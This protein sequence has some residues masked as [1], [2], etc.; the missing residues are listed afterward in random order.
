MLTKHIFLVGFMGVGKTT[1]GRKLAQ[2]LNSDFIDLDELFVQQEGTS[3]TN[4]FKIHGEEHF[5]LKEREIIQQLTNY[6]PAVIATGGGAPCFFDNMEW[7]NTHGITVYLQIPAAAL[8][9]RLA[10]SKRHKRPLIQ[11]LNEDEILDF[12]NE[13]MQ[14]RHPFYAKAHH[15]VNVIDLDIDHLIQTLCL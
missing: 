6:S 7:M 12:I 2:A 1:N 15:H 11:H 9:H 14:H 10:A 3:I 5:R 4:Y 13:R 8:A